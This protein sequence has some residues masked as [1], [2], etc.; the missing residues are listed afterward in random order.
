MSLIHHLQ[1]VSDYRTKPHYPLWV[2]ML[3][4]IM[5]IMSGCN[6]YRALESFVERHQ[7]VLLELLELP[8]DR[9]P[10]FTTLRRIMIRI[11]FV[12][13]TAAFNAWAAETFE[14]SNGEQL[15]TDGKSIKAS[16]RDYDKSYQDFISVVSAFSVNQGVVIGLRSMHNH[17]TSEIATVQSLLEVLN[18]QGACFTFDALHTQK[19]LS[20]KSSIAEMTI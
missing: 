3:L 7:S 18:V 19:K 15:A 9:L 10:S 17:D 20:G 5:G 4:V 14:V 8:F 2:V 11:S 6:G 16:V 13:L 1:Q 12:S